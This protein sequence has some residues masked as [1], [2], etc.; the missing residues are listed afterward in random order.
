MRPETAAARFDM[1]VAAELLDE[2]AA[3]DSE[4]RSIASPIDWWT[5]NSVAPSEKQIAATAKKVTMNASRPTIE[6]IGI[7]SRSWHGVTPERYISSLLIK[8]P[9]Q[10]GKKV[11]A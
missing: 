4:P 3:R 9:R 6:Y 7:L 10:L 11:A 5:S 2:V 1:S 8:G